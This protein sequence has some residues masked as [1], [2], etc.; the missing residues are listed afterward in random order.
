MSGGRAR[1]GPARHLVIFARYPT[2]GGGKRRLAA[3]VGAIEALRFQRGRLRVL[4]AR[5]S[6]DPRW[7]TW[8]AVTPDRS[9]PWPSHVKTIRQGGGDLGA[10]L[11]RVV[12]TLPRG[13]AV[14]I[15]TDIPGIEAAH[16]AKAFRAIAGHDGV[17]GPAT[18]G[19]YWLI[20]L[21]LCPRLRLP[22]AP[23]RW[24]SEHALAD[25]ARN[26]AG[27]R[28]AMLGVLEDVDDA[29]SLKRLGAGERVV[30]HSGA[31]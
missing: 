29:M 19:G 9:G 10:R 15:G 6:A 17:L 31:P 25:T 26:L 8:I 14:I 23:V 13:P 22:F 7:T 1:N 27:A 21:R 24:S 20:G 30:R 18:D 4:L 28:V 5:L 12:R 2:A 16:I 3:S 11:A